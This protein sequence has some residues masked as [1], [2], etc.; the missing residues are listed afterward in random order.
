VEDD[1]AFVRSLVHRETPMTAP[2]LTIA[3]TTFNRA[4]ALRRRFEELARVVTPD[5]EVV[6][7]NNGSSDDT[8]A[9]GA[10]AAARYPWL[11]FQ[12]NVSN[13]GN[14]PSGLRLLEVARG[15]WCWIL[16]DDEP[17]AWEE[18]GSLL[19]VLEAETAAIVRLRGPATKRGGGGPRVYSSVEELIR[20]LPDL[21]D[22]QVG[23]GSILRTA[24]ALPHLRAAYR[25]AGRLHVI[26]PLQFEMIRAGGKLKMLDLPLLN[27]RVLGTPRY[28]LLEAHLGAWETMRECVPRHLR[29]IV[30]EAHCRARWRVLVKAARA[31]TYGDGPPIDDLQLRRILRVLPLRK[32]RHLV[33]VFLYLLVKGW[34][35][36][37]ADDHGY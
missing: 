20:T 29:P 18:F 12:S 3:I 4:A 32:W 8:A 9:V 25:W 10:E 34:R 16:G 5:V 30:D 28:P 21:A 19:A 15:T 22:A 33:G 37:P 26:T 31:G 11:R 17:V 2:F 27:A 13:L 23:S 14:D 7:I 6:V 1:H 36:H 35:T 24:A